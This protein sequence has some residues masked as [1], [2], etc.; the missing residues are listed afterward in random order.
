MIIAT[1]TMS[2]EKLA[3]LILSRDQFLISS[4]TLWIDNTR[5]SQNV[6]RFGVHL[7]GSSLAETRKT[8]GGERSSPKGTKR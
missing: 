1:M 6:T 7:I 3:C 4:D 2:K 5:T 8:S